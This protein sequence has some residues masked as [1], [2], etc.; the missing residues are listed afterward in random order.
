MTIS[1]FFDITHERELL[2]TLGDDGV[3]YCDKP[4]D[5][6]VDYN[7][8]SISIQDSYTTSPQITILTLKENCPNI[9]RGSFFKHFNKR[10]VVDQVMQTTAVHILV[11]VNYG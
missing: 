6:I 10:L 8:Q 4:I 9:K 7:Q 1:H 11:S 3:S 2:K 5:A